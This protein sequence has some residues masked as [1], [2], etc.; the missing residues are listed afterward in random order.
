MGQNKKKKVKWNL[1]FVLDILADNRRLNK[2]NGI[3]KAFN[4]IM[5]AHRGEVN[6]TVTSAKVLK[7]KLVIMSTIL[8]TRTH[9]NCN[10]VELTVF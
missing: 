9:I 8:V 3:I 7:T 6:C 2:V 10:N 5:S 4:T 1:T